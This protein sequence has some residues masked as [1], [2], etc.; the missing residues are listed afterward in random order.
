EGRL[1]HGRSAQQPRAAFDS[2]DAEQVIEEGADERQRE[3]HGDPAERRLRPALVEQRMQR[4]KQP[5]RGRDDGQYGAER[6]H[7]GHRGMELAEQAYPTIDEP[8]RREPICRNATKVKETA[9]P[10]A[11]TTRA[12]ARRR[13]AASERSPRRFRTR[14]AESSSAPRRKGGAT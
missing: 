4:G 13:S 12:R 1:R 10:R 8:A 7:S 6:L 9:R 11:V 14:S 5:E 2:I 3:A